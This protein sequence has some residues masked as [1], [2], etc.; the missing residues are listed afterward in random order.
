MMG[1]MHYK[2]TEWHSRPS[3]AQADHCQRSKAISS[4]ANIAV[5]RRPKSNHQ[6]LPYVHTLLKAVKLPGVERRLESG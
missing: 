5:I 2:C 1:V 3:S 4:F 6:N